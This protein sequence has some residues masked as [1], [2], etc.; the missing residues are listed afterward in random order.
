LRE[1]Y[2]SDEEIIS[3]IK[4]CNFKIELQV[5]Q[6]ENK[7]KL[8]VEQCKKNLKFLEGV[9]EEK[10]TE[11]SKIMPKVAVS[12]KKSKPKKPFKQDGTLS[13]IGKKWFTM[14]EEMGLPEDY[15][16]EVEVITKYIEPNPQSN[17]QIKDFLFSKN[18][19][20]KIFKDGANGKVPQLRDDDKN[21]CSSITSMFK[22]YPE[23]E[24]LEGL[25]VAQ[26]RAGYLKAFLETMDEDGYV[27]ASWMAMAKT[28]RVK[29]IKPIV[30]IPANNSQ[31]GELIRSTL[32]APEG[33]VFVNADLSSLEDKTKQIGIYDIDREYVDQL[34]VPGYDAHLTIALRAGFMTEDEVSFFK[35]YKRKDKSR[36]DSDF[37]KSFSNLTDKEMSETFDKLVKTRSGAKTTNYAATYKASAKKIGETADLPLKEAKI[38]HKAYW[39][40]NWSILKLEDSFKTKFA[41]GREWIYSPFSKTWLILTA[42]HIK[43]SAVNQNFGAKVFDLW[44][45]FLI[46]EGVKPIMSMHDEVSW[47]IDEGQEKETEKLVKRAIDKVNRIF[48]HPIKF[49]AEPEFAKSYGDVH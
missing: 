34:N 25:S 17:T 12:I 21:L 46:Q 37:P 39:D 7:I 11:V 49:E 38:F 18:W 35:W 10:T 19:K 27:T 5:I 45:Y 41:D 15:N 44:V 43:F 33:K 29:H 6:E 32:I 23:L 40:L 26:H 42:Q 24:N 13:S 3:I 48:N 14:L 28:W 36:D 16:G 31:Y 47:Y 4:H 30:N 20:P 2:S 8:A 1:L 9:I 22:D